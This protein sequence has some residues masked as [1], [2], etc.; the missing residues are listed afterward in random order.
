MKYSAPF[1]S[2]K[3]PK[4]KC[5][6]AL[7]VLEVFSNG[8]G[9]NASATPDITIIMDGLGLTNDEVT[10]LQEYLLYYDGLVK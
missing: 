2:E 3:H 6:P 4:P 9:N 5:A 10:H 8:N 7:L 1:L